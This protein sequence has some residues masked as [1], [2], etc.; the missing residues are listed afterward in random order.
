MPR[1]LALFLVSMLA[2]GC[3]LDEPKG[4]SAPPATT[5]QSTAKPSDRPPILGPEHS[6]VD[7]ERMA[8]F[9]EPGWQVPRAIRYSP[10][11]KL[12]TFLLGEG[13][14]DTMAL[15][16]FDLA[17]QRASV[18][19]RG[20]DLAKNDKPLSREEEL[21][22]ERQRKRIQGVTDYR[23]ARRVN[24]MVIPYGG[25]LFARDAAGAI[26]R[27]TDSPSPEID[28]K[29]SDDGTQ[30]AFVRG[31]ELAVI[32]VRSRKETALTQG[33]PEGVTRGLSDYIAQ[34]E[35]DEE[36]GFWWSPGGDRIAY[37]EVD[38]RGVDVLPVTG[39]RGGRADLMQQRYPRAGRRNASVK[40][41]ILEI[42]TRKT[43]WVTLPE[44]EHY[45]GRFQWTPDGRG[46]V[47]QAISRDQKRLA[48]LRADPATGAAKELWSSSSSTWVTFSK[49]K[50]LERS[51]RLVAT[52]AR[53]GHVHLDLRD[54][55][56]GDRIAEL[57]RGS[58]GVDALAGVDEEHGRV[59]F[60]GTFTSPV[61][62]RL[63]AVPLAGGAVETLTMEHGVHTVTMAPRARGFVDEHSAGDRVPRTVVHAEGGAVIGELPAP[64]DPD[65][66]KLHLRTPEII[67]VKSPGGPTLY[68]ALLKPRDM[69]PGRRYPVVVMVYGGPGVQTVLDAWSPRLLWQHLADRGF[70]VFQL[71]NRGS[72]GR[73]PAF[74]APIHERLGE[75]ELADQLAGLD[76]LAAMPFVDASRVAIYGHSYGGFMAALAMLKAPGRF[77][78]GIAGSPVTSWAFYDTGYTERF[79][80]TPEKNPAGYEASDLGR[81]AA[82]L[83]GKLL[84]IHALM[85]ENV[86]FQHTAHLVDALVAADKKFDL[87]VFPGERHGY[88]APAARRYALRRVVDYLVENL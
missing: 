10:D 55:A 33:A 67:Q 48:V 65:V 42:K 54:A 32:D 2:I 39:Y 60:T 35:F 43:T 24:V 78:V 29:P 80:S 44:G 13:Q 85:D 75:A 38:E 73:G 70:V 7:F 77:K 88:R 53:D 46:L 81:M 19:V 8:R 16:A 87:F 41:G 79:M 17:T 61:E 40:V 84:V 58:F 4:P 20:S 28:P 86:H 62:R 34:E 76:A 56:T 14:S 12:I 63:H 6:P 72:S 23:W 36:S 37:L 22:R 18:L 66:A 31:S 59:Y 9:P 68:G 21:R 5:M 3:H 52:A 74:E 57:T 71:D 69:E 50:L 82:G 83:Q 64:P 30:V 45:L 26:T 1:P 25:D 27:L 11:G 51:P 49:V 15:F 47:F